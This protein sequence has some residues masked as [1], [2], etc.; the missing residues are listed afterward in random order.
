MTPFC[1]FQLLLQTQL[2][3]AA[4]NSSCTT[5][6]TDTTHVTVAS[7]A[8]Q[9]PT[10]TQGSVSSS[11]IQTLVTDGKTII[12]SIPV[13]VGDKIQIDRLNVSSQ[14]KNK[15]EKRT[16]HNAIEKRYRLSIN[17]KIVELRELVAG[18]DSSKVC[19]VCALHFT[20]YVCRPPRWPSG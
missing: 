2:V 10:S 1:S 16:P 12:T 8:A 6:K 11:P 4:G 3:N 20:A 17:D 18:K 5:G 15:G 14:L 9:S 13:Q 19:M 7:P